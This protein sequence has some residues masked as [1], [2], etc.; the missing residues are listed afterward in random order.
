MANNTALNSV[1]A[2]I[3]D[4]NGN[5]VPNA[6][7]KF[8]IAGGTAGG[9]ATL[10]DPDGDNIINTDA[11]GD[12]IIY[13][14]SPKT[15]TVDMSASVNGSP[16][17]NATGGLT[18]TVTFVADNP[19]TGNPGTVLVTLD[20]MRVAD[21]AAL[22]SVKVTI[23]DANGNPVP[24]APVQFTI[25]GGSA[26]G[27]ATLIDPDGDNIINTDANGIAIMYI[28]SPK[29][30]TVDMSATVNGSPIPAMSGGTIETVTFVADVPNTGN[31]ATLLSPLD[32]NRVANNIALNSVKV[33]VV[34]ANGNPVPNAPVQFTIAGGTAGGSATLIDP[35]G[36]N[37]I[38]TDAN[39][40][41]IMYLKSLKTG[42]VDMSA[43]VNGSPIKNATG[44]LTVTVTF[45]ADAPS[46]GN[47]ATVLS[48]LDDKR[49]ADNTALN[50]VKAHIA[51]ANGN[52]V[53]NAPVKFTIAGGTAG[54]AT[55][56]DPDG[57]NIINT[58]ANGDAIMYIKSPDVGTVEISA[59]VNGASIPAVSGGT[60]ETVT[61]VVGPPDITKPAT[62]LI[63]KIDSVVAN[64]IALNS[65]LAHIVDAAGRPVANASIVFTLA[66][67]A[68]TI[69]ETNPLLTDANGDAVITLHSTVAGNITITATVNGETI[70]FG[71][72]APLTFV[73][74]DPDPSK[75][76]TELIVVKNHAQADGKATNSVKAHI[77][78]AHGN[79]VPK[80]SVV[81]TIAN[82]IAS[83]VETNPVITDA[84]GDAIIR[85]TSTVGD[86]VEIT[87]TVNGLP[88]TFGS[89]AKVV[90]VTDPDVTAPDTKLIVVANDAIADGVETNS[91]KAHIVD[92][93]GIPLYQKEVFFRIESGDAT[94][95]TIQ[96]VLTDANGD[97]T[98][99]L[100]SKT[101][102][103]VQV[104][105]KVGDKQ[106]LHGSPAKL[107]FVPI[108]IYVPKVFTP[109]NDGTNDIV[110]PIV[111]GI[112]TFHYFNIYNRWGNLV[113]TTKDPNV[114]WDGRFKGVL[115]PVETYLW[116]AEG[117]DK[118]KKKITRRGMISLVR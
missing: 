68:A 98:I 38:N 27:S 51:D 78:D 22:N 13:L 17:K 88:I 82:G 15:G 12:A 59:T 32:D 14:K 71:S 64:G 61:F 86:T 106:I 80:A 44:G 35:D 74:G 73:P 116:I 31:P 76:A 28:K 21:N 66:S 101:A 3:V 48:K 102:G 99:L 53:P 69:V 89:P 108:D 30:G 34:D 40:D 109:N 93:T 7:V 113:F 19:S 72:P 63:V 75:P 94:V 18:V 105:A 49:V 111:V 97:A 16:I 46:T 104:T 84:N 110:K 90:F 54:G 43:S 77:V 29:A 55:L 103:P 2:H 47:P 1:K 115:Q 100:A 25:A 5:P 33:H 52:P 26:G 36:D 70:T 39:G 87:A 8:A 10:V 50:S 107:R 4:A 6:P 112:T 117:L 11:N 65:V 23:A 114:G 79:K 83:F 9:S 56:V 92:A 118:D 91:V 58:D 60:T 62:E 37:I 45:V 81:F 95:L 57:D 41:A 42:T 67:G 96:P 24:N 20:D 85:L